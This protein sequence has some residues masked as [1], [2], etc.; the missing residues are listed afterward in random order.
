MR[1][2]WNPDMR[3][4]EQEELSTRHAAVAFM[5][6]TTWIAR[7]REDMENIL[8]DA[9]SFYKANDSQINTQKSILI[10]IN[11]KSADPGVVHTGTTHEPVM[12]LN[13]G[14]QARFLEI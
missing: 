14:K 4:T 11:N 9:R 2:T 8:E 10:T 12:E 7:S 5:D 1:T 13:R 3:N 6:D